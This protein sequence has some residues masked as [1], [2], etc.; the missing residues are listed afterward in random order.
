MREVAPQGGLAA[1]AQYVCDR[2]G[3]VNPVGADFCVSCHAFL[4]WDEIEEDTTTKPDETVRSGEPASSSEQN[5]ETKVMPQIR[6]PA[7]PAE[8]ETD[9]RSTSWHDG[10]ADSTEALFRTIDKQR[11]ITVPATGEPAGLVVQIT[12]T[13]TIVDGYVVEAPNAPDW[14][15]LEAS[16]VGLLPGTEEA[17][18]VPMRVAS[19]R[20]V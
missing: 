4:A 9:D 15:A 18:P 2:C 10:P 3:A 6:V 1:M 19:A 17:L 14:L 13:S 20:L 8:A 11:E 12:N 16:Q 5:E 7:R